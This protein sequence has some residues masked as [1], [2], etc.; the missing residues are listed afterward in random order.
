MISTIDFNLLPDYFHIC[1]S[2]TNNGLLCNG[3]TTSF[4]LISWESDTKD[5][6]ITNIISRCSSHLI[7]GWAGNA[8]IRQI[9]FEEILIHL[10]YNN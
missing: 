1:M 10:I 3:I 4:Y 8:M 2:H 5:S 9:S 6:P 7:A